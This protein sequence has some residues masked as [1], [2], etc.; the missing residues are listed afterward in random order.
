MKS[1]KKI[2]IAI[3][4]PAGAGKSTI[5]KKLAEKLSYIYVD[6]GAL[7][8]AVAVSTF[9]ISDENEIVKKANSLNIEIKFIGG[10]Q[11]IFVNDK[12]VN[13]LLR[14]NE[15]SKKASDVSA[16]KGVR[17]YLLDLQK[18]IAKTNNVIMDG[19]DIGTVILPK[20]QVK[21]F[22]VASPEVRA[23]RRYLELGEKIPYDKILSDI[24]ERDYNDTH[25]A[26]APLRQAEDA[27]LFDTS[28]LSI[29]EVV[30]RI[31]EIIKNKTEKI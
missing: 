5:A 25:R 28:D 6:T 1:D 31:Y 7:Y 24:N 8:R 30:D 10:S 3:D 2:N 23:K 27:L 19:R 22:L 9:D 11:H 12:D 16:I 17:D 13:H 26:E 18:N 15:I 14:T 29:E 21:I 4:G 20:A